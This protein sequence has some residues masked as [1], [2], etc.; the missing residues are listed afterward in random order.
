MGNKQMKETNKY[1]LIVGIF[2]LLT[3]FLHD[4]LSIPIMYGIE[5]ITA[6]IYGL[7]P[8][9]KSNINLELFIGIIAGLSS[10]F[11]SAIGTTYLFAKI[12][13]LFKKL[14]S[15]KKWQSF[16]IIVLISTIFI[17]SINIADKYKIVNIDIYSNILLT[18]IS[19]TPAYLFYLFLNRLGKKHP[20]FYGKIGYYCSV[21]FYKKEKRNAFKVLINF[22]LE[23]IN[24]IKTFV[25]QLS[26]TLKNI[27][28]FILLAFFL[29]N[30]LSTL[31]IY[32]FR[33]EQIDLL[34][35]ATNDP[36]LKIT[37]LSC[38]IIS[39]IFAGILITYF[40]AKICGLFKKLDNLKKGKRI[41]IIILTITIGA[42]THAIL[43]KFNISSYENRFSFMLANYELIPAY[44]M[45]LFFNR[46]GK[47]HPHTFGR[48][49]YY[50]SVE[51]YKEIFKKII[52]KI[53]NK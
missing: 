37:L 4:K 18:G 26:S 13:G 28:V 5:N 48:S 31:F 38:S 15:L 27:L 36:L 22:I 3:T 25:L 35:K 33:I 46:L 42:I 17:I 2:L 9:F 20:N 47:K 43:D 49:G 44:L 10:F 19:L 14:D 11:M 6:F 41:L 50:C 40:F 21:E 53:K 34:G 29:H 24:S 45:H 7:N 51:F 23:C 52:T 1:L 39:V 16:L 30:I 32:I 12:C 8:I